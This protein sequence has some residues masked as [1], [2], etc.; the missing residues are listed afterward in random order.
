M[1]SPLLRLLPLFGPHRLLLAAGAGGLVLSS[2]LS[3][4]APVVL[5]DAVDTDLA[6]GDAAGLIRR[7][8]VYAALVVANLA[9]TWGARVA[10]ETSAQRAMLTLKERLFDH[11]LGHDVA[12]HDR[13]AS[14]SLI[15]RVQGDVEALR[16]L[17]VEVLLA[18][19]ADALLAVGMVAVLVVRSPGVAG[20]VLAAIPAYAALLWVFRRVAGPYF[21]AQRQ[22]L[23]RMTG[24]LAETVR[25]MPALRALGRNGWAR[26]RA[27]GLV[28]EAA[29]ADLM[30]HLQPVW[31]F[32]T[33]LAIRAVATTAVLMW[34]AGLVATGD[35]TVGGL[36]M[37]LAYLRQLFAPLMRLSN[38]LATLERA[39]AS[40]VRVAELFDDAPRV[41]DPPSPVPWP[42]LRRAIRFEG[43]GFHYLEGTPVL[44][45]LDLE[46]PA[47]ARVGIVGPTGS[48]KSTVLDLVLRFRDP[49]SGRVTVDGVDLRDLSLAD[50]RRRTGLVLQDVRL[51]PG[52]VRD[53]LGGDPVAAR[54]ALDAL[55]VTL[56]LDQVVDDTVL[57][58]GERQLLTFARALVGDPELLVLDEATSAIDPRT[59]DRVQRA[60][61]KLMEGRTVLIVAHRLETVRD[62]DRIVVLRGGEVLEAGS[63]D[64]LLARNG[65]YAE[66]V[67][68]Q[69]AA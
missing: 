4:A 25:T 2:A 24:A 18:L 32:N 41:V 60:L 55:G 61:Q 11:L 44:R 14:G 8:A 42:G 66:M 54:A 30:A 19:P 57:S 40:A 34:G 62:C 53:N 29:R 7:S 26:D 69:E 51:I 59:E 67:R 6:N 21:L 33:A 49:V 45:S 35:A 1:R 65:T 43:V 56:P 68:L 63:H 48:G 15:G 22:V 9:V 64:E 16:V 20:P 46:L 13:T 23:S 37:A 38:Q 5:A 3:V 52:T 50:L 58:R 31:Y 10:L 12:F 28:K 17:F 39:R 27:V 47:G 36:L